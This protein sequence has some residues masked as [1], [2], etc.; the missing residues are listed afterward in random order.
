MG[1]DGKWQYLALYTVHW[2]LYSERLGCTN[3]QVF[4]WMRELS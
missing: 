3:R 1:T 4:C 2:T